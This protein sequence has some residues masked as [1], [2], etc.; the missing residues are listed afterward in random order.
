LFLNKYIKEWYSKYISWVRLIPRKINIVP[1]IWFFKGNK[2]KKY[3][4][5]N[6]EFKVAFKKY[7]I[8][9]HFSHSEFINTEKLPNVV[10]WGMD[11]NNNSIKIW[12]ELEKTYDKKRINKKNIDE[13]LKQVVMVMQKIDKKIDKKLIVK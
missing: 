12:L 3:A 13:I 11:W 4:V 8:P 2:I 10:S 5:V 7:S 1:R 6:E 9:F